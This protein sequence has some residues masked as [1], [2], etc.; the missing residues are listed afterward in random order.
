MLCLGANIRALD[1]FV[2]TE[3]FRTGNQ[4]IIQAV[5]AAL[6]TS[7]KA[8]KKFRNMAALPRSIDNFSRETIKDILTNNFWYY[9]AI[10][11]LG[12]K[13]NTDP[14]EILKRSDGVQT[15]LEFASASQD[16]MAVLVLLGHPELKKPDILKALAFNY[17]SKPKYDNSMVYAFR[18]QLKLGL[19]GGFNHVLWGAAGSDGYNFMTRHGWNEI[20]AERILLKIAIA[21][22]KWKIFST[23]AEYGTYDLACNDQEMLKH[24]I[25]FGRDRMVA[26]MLKLESI[27]PEQL[28]AEFFLHAKKTGNEKLVKLMIDDGRFIATDIIIDAMTNEQYTEAEKFMKKRRQDLPIVLQKLVESRKLKILA[29]FLE[30]SRMSLSG[31]NAKIFQATKDESK[32]K[33]L[34]NHY[35]QIDLL[36]YDSINKDSSAAMRFVIVVT[37]QPDWTIHVRQQT[38]NFLKQ[39]W[40]EFHVDN[41]SVPM[42]DEEW[43]QFWSLK[44]VEAMGKV[45]KEAKRNSYQDKDLK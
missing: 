44:L 16:L 21:F 26:H 32:L 4:K 8:L 9:E 19:V 38:D 31:K 27:H 29:R 1:G 18:S 3:A 42:T 36:K 7:S 39:L 5:M 23:V 12:M 13:L 25:F 11:A 15:F 10:M 45:Q 2:I 35:T 14:R 37:K 24:A 6:D 28:S 40:D 20:F 34:I 33:T 41:V 17:L 30:M 22:D 43:N